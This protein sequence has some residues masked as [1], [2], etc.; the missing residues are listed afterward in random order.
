LATNFHRRVREPSIFAGRPTALSVGGPGAS[1]VDREDRG[2]R[3]DGD[4]RSRSSTVGSCCYLS[5]QLF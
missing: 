2:L 5:L 1:Y 4:S 3:L